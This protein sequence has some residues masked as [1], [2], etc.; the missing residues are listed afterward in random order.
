MGKYPCKDRPTM[1]FLRWSRDEEENGDPLQ[2]SC[3]ENPMDRGA[4][5]P[6]VPEVT[7]SR[8]QLSTDTSS[9]SIWH[10]YGSFGVLMTPD[11]P[12]AYLGGFRRT[13][14]LFWHL[15]Y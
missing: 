1:K 13:F 3:L 4:W 10:N 11:D 9:R 6:T 5:W 7:K 15:Y 14:G 12:G 2:Y 8:I